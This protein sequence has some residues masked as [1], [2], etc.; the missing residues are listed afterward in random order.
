[1]L[2]AASCREGFRSETVQDSPLD[3][4]RVMPI[5]IFDETPAELP[6]YEESRAKL[7]RISAAW[8]CARTH[9]RSFR[10]RIPS[11]WCASG[12]SVGTFF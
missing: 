8:S 5:S 3:F 9:A 4:R 1:M 11:G 2:H 12:A 6:R 7:A 10:A